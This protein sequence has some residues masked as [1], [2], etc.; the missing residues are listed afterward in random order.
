[1]AQSCPENLNFTVVAFW[2][3]GVRGGG[4]GLVTL[5][6][7]LSF[8]RVILTRVSKSALRFDLHPTLG[9]RRLSAQ[10]LKHLMVAW[11]RSCNSV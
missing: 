1:M 11:L 3:V 2:G 10:T 8:V 5:Y 6:Q 9:A 4:H 7:V